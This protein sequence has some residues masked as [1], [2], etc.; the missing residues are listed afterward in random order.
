MAARPDLVEV[1]TQYAPSSVGPYLWHEFPSAQVEHDLDAIAHAR[2]SVV[3]VLLGWDA[4]MPT[5]RQ[6]SPRRM[7][8][9]ESL[10]GAARA[11][12][13]RVIPVLFVQ[14]LGDCVMLPRWAVDVQAP[15]RGVRVLTDGRV[16]RG[17]PRDAWAD[18]LMI[19][20]EVRWVDALLAAFAGHPAVAAW[21]L[22]HDP[23]TAVRPRRI[24]DVVAWTELLGGRLREQGEQVCLTLGER[25]LTLAR[26][27]RPQLVAPFVDRL[28]MAVD[29]RD[30]DAGRP[31]FLAWLLRRFTGDTVPLHIEVETPVATRADDGPLP[32]GVHDDS[33]ATRALVDG[34]L[35]RVLETRASGVT[36]AAWSD[37]GPRVLVAPPCDRDPA[38]ASAGITDSAGNFKNANEPWRLLAA[39]APAPAGGEPAAPRIDSDDW[40]A[41]LPES[42]RETRSAWDG[43][44]REGGGIL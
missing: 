5:D 33:V 41:N 23:A 24:A 44:A 40:Y 28:A 20:A 36:A 39:S 27:V 14:A 21:D 10:L 18:P 4:F 22:G 19:E 37:A 32:P 7:R 6:V 11:R 1:A 16:A 13:M 2:I 38:R 31:A 30:G 29:L 25:D 35:H 15:R 9:L 17:G 3:R 42:L 26:A 43:V 12:A 8:E 34:A